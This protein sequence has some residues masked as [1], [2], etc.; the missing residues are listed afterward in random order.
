MHESTPLATPQMQ[1]PLSGLVSRIGLE[2]AL[3]AYQGDAS[4]QALTLMVV[5]LSRF[6]SVNESMGA[7]LGNKIIK[8]ISKRLITIFPTAALIARTHGN[9]FCLLFEGE[10]DVDAQVE[11]LNDFTQ[12]PL[13]LSGQI[14]VLT[15]CIGIATLGALVDTPTELLHA[16]EVA[17]HRAKREGLKHSAYQ[18]H[19]VSEAKAAHQL[20]NDLRISLVTN[21]AELHKAI[22]NDEFKVVY[23]PI[24]D[25]VHHKVHAFEALMRWH[26]P[27]R[28]IVSPNV[29]IP[30]AESIQLMDI[31]GSWVMRRACMDAM[32][33]PPNADG[34]LPALSV[35]VSGTQF[36]NPDILLT[37]ITQALKDAGLPA[38][39][40]KIEITESTAFGM[41]KIDIVNKI[42]DM[43]CSIALDD[44]GTGFSSLTQLIATP[45]DYIKL[46]TS[47]IQAIG[48]DNQQAEQ[49]S[50]K[51]TRAVLSIAQA[52]K[53]QT[54]VEGVE[55][56]AQ[57]DK[58]MQYGGHLIQ[59]YYFSQP[60]PLEQACQFVTAFNRAIR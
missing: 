9:H 19:F 1:D 18:S 2:R 33:F 11:L 56:A 53:M 25:V 15:V 52:L 5:E 17:L 27:Q 34:S 32:S 6:G 35:N 22:A 42:R 43:G 3:S 21:H 10:I 14:I 54:I 37:A 55:T 4:P 31:L 48:R 36:H 23:Q 49:R 41:K 45:L 47:F 60:L 28:G 26:H 50:D 16:A 29:F 20:E 7:A 12:R 24:V 58:L 30:M 46:D 57:C 38:S 13:A 39:R 59:G 8:T 44:F 51:L 40:L